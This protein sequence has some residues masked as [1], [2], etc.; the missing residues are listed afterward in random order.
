MRDNGADVVI[1]SSDFRAMER[2]SCFQVTRSRQEAQFF[3]ALDGLGAAGGSELVEGAGTMSLDGVFGNEKLRGNLAI[4]ETPGHQG[5]DFEFACR[6]AEGLLLGGIGSEGFEGG[7]FHGDKDLLH[8]HRF[9]DDFA[10]ARDAEAEPDAERREEDGDERA[11]EFDGVLN[12]DEAVF[13]ELQ[14]SDEESADQTVDEDV[15]L[16]DGL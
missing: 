15:A 3:A 9:A 16:H 11:V 2:K 6:N 8:H 12:D 13:G 5:E 14:G 7:G 10:A 4:A 1:L